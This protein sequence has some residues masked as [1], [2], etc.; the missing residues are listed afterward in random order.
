MQVFFCDKRNFATFLWMVVG[1]LVSR[2]LSLPMWHCHLPFGV[3]AAS[4]ER[5]FSRWL[6]NCRINPHDLYECLFRHAMRFW[7]KHPILLA[8]DTSML[9]DRFCALRISMLY[10]GR[11]IPVAWRIIEHGSA[12]VKFDPYKDLLERVRCLLPQDVN[13]IFLA[14][15]GFVNRKLMRALCEF[16]WEWRIRMCL[17]TQKLC[18]RARKSFAPVNP[19]C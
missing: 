4:T 10:M 7:T 18:K 16:G 6:H 9:Q 8:I 2:S 1:A 13:V 11:A 14:D 15:R 5:R 12:S 17:S 3:Q 19:E